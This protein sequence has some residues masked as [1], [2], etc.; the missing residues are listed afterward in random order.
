MIRASLLSVLLC[1]TACI[2]DDYDAYTPID[3]SG[4]DTDP[5]DSDIA[6]VGQWRSEGADIAPLLAGSP[7][8]YTSVNA[9]FR[10]DMSYT[11][12]AT[13]ASS[14]TF[15]LS[16]T[17]AVN[18]GTTPATV[19]LTQ[20]EPYEAIARGIWSVSG[21]E[22]TYEV[23]Q[24]EPDF[25]FSAPTAAAGFGSTAGQGLTAGANVQVYRRR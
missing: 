24:T 10:A 23:V 3:D 18:E 4:A 9:V 11:V 6:L 7:F 14:A 2:P 1:S 12:T 25:G 21:D 17:F 19:T 15:P 13:D 20:S 8:N 16:G 5:G 22:L